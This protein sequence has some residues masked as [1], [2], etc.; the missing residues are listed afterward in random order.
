MGLIWHSV[1]SAFGIKVRYNPY[2][3]ELQLRCAKD[4]PIRLTESLDFWY[5]QVLVSSSRANLP[6]LPPKER[7]GRRLKLHQKPPNQQLKPLMKSY[8]INFTKRLEAP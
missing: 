2:Y 3:Q 5:I 8:G 6:P 7:R 1:I 4:V